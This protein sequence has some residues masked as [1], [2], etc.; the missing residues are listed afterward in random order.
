MTETTYANAWNEEY[1]KQGIPSSHRDEPSGV[2]LWALANI[3][4]ITD[5]KGSALDLGCGTGRNAMALAEAGYSISGMDFSSAALD[6]ARRRP[7]ADEI[8]FLEGD[9]TEP[10]PMADASCGIVTDI[11]VYFHQLGD[12][13]RRRYRQEMR[14]VLR[15]EGVLLVS[16]ATDED[17]YY[18]QCPQLKKSEYGSSMRLT[19]DPHAKVGNIL[20]SSQDFFIEFSD[21]FE[22]SMTWQK[23]KVGLM[24]GEEYMRHTLASLWTPKK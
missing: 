1:A 11:F 2:L 3:G 22:L 10:L 18:G 8:T 16:L 12:E 20:L 13:Q 19:Y 17:G 6:I 24:H 21:L 9:V 5:G 4:F 15:P 23:R 7:G 14:R